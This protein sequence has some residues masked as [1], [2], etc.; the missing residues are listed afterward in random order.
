MLG[1]RVGELNRSVTPTGLKTISLRF[2]EELDGLEFRIPW[3]VE[4]QSCDIRSNS[5]IEAIADGRRSI[6]CV[7][8]RV[9]L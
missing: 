7:L 8:N 9:G 6:V 4:L 5:Q 3:R 1:K 2:G